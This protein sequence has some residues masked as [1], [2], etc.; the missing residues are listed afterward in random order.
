M[1]DVRGHVVAM[2]GGGFLSG[3]LHSPLDDL[4]PYALRSHYR[5]RRDYPLRLARYPVV[6][7]RTQAEI[8]AFL[9]AAAH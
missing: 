9:N 6:R 2:G 3:D 7:L 5:R 4:I 8:D 1:P